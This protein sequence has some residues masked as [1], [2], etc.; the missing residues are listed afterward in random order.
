MTQGNAAAAG[1]LLAPQ[2]PSGEA[3]HPP[4]L[5]L[6]AQH[7]R[8]VAEGFSS[9]LCL[10]I[11]EP[12]LSRSRRGDGR[13]LATSVPR[14]PHLRPPSLLRHPR[15]RGRRQRSTEDRVIIQRQ[16]GQQPRPDFL[17]EAR[18]V[19]VLRTGVAPLEHVSTHRRPSQQ[20]DSLTADY[21][22]EEYSRRL[23]HHPVSGP[24]WRR[25]RA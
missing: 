16:Q 5:C 9:N 3:Q 14:R 25:R 23:H 2:E 22:S 1:S 10:R 21:S 4:R 24:W 11:R 15:H 7:L 17:R 12:A 8:G 13:G 6:D 18:P 20:R 19:R